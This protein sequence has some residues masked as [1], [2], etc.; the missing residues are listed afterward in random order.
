MCTKCKIKTGFYT[1]VTFA[2]SGFVGAATLVVVGKALG[3]IDVAK[4]VEEKV[5]EK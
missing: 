1:L 3:I 5:E 4:K 2:T